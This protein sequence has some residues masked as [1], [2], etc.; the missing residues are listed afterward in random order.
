VV[1]NGAHQIA[2]MNEQHSM[3]NYDL[4]L[5]GPELQGYMREGNQVIF[6]NVLP[7]LK[8]LL[9]G[10]P[11]TGRTALQWDMQTL[12]EEQTLVQPMYSRMSQHAF[13][14]LDYIAHKTRFA[15]W[16]AWWSDEDLVADQPNVHGGRVPGFDQHD[17]RSI[18]DRWHYGMNLGN[19]FTPGGSGFNAATDALPSVDAS[20]TGGAEFARVDWRSHLH[21]I[22]AWLGTHNA[23]SGIPALISAL[24]SMNDREKGEM[25]ADSSPEGWAY[26]TELA[27]WKQFGVT[28]T[29]VRGALPS[30]AASAP[31]VETFVATFN[32]EATR[33][34]T[35]VGIPRYR[36]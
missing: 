12:A 29:I 36:R 15:G 16:G 28:E 21:F 24:G 31:A 2:D 19:R 18:S 8:R 26:S 13:D 6:E 7:K 20:Y 35:P 30:D 14:Q 32:H 22:D 5:A 3:A 17:L 27:P 23:R 25:L 10:G 9:D 34:G 11:I 4:D 1:A 33:Y